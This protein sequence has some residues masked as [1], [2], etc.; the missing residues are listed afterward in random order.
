MI[1]RAFQKGMTSLIDGHLF[2]FTLNWKR[3]I[4]THVKENRTTFSVLY[5]L[6]YFHFL[7]GRGMLYFE[8]V[9]F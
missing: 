5:I 9:I 8:C 6:K 2:L 4:E 3:H 7:K 1:K